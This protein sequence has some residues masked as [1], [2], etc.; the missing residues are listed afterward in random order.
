MADKSNGTLPALTSEWGGLSPHLIGTFFAIKKVVSED[1]KSIRWER[2]TTQP[3]VCAPLT[4]ANFEIV[5][6]WQSP[7]ENMGPD[8]KFSSFSAMLQAG[9]FSALLAQLKKVFPN[10]DMVDS[11]SEKAS[12][13]FG[14]SNLTKLN[15]TQ[16]FTGMPPVKMPVTAHFRAYKDADLEVRRPIE[17]LMQWALPKKIAE[18]GPIAQAAGGNLALFPSDVPQI[19]G[20]KYADMLLAP[21]VIESIPFPMSGPRDSNGILMQASLTIQLATLTAIDQNDWVEARSARN[22]AAYNY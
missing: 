11:A 2:D 16:V 1:K 15:S 22:R 13:F 17:K 8:Q 20:L 9:G 6:N 10:S 7:F 3:E 19:I 4:D 5:L 18:D 12:K 21:L 14:R